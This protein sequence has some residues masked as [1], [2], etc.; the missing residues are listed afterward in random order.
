[1]SS[2]RA[3]AFKSLSP[4]RRTRGEQMFSAL[5]SIAAGSEP[6]QECLGWGKTPVIVNLEPN[7]RNGSELTDH[8][9]VIFAFSA[10]P[11]PA[12]R[13][14]QAERIDDEENSA[15]RHKCHLKK[16]FARTIVHAETPVSESP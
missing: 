4:V 14:N 16:L 12:R 1:M 7:F 2:S 8:L 9:K 3:S 13:P 6:C 10:M 15:E 5:P 11:H